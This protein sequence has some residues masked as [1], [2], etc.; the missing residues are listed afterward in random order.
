VELVAKLAG[1]VGHGDVQ[2]IT[3]FS[4]SAAG[5]IAVGS[6]VWPPFVSW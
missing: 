4:Q 3:H 6:I 1:I 5:R 2:G